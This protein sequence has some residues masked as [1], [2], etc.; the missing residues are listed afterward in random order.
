[1]QKITL[2]QAFAGL[3]L[4]N[5]VTSPEGKILAP[6][7]S[8]LDSAVLRRLELAGIAKIVVQGKPVPDASMGYDAGGRATRL[9]FLFRKYLDD[10]FMLTLKNMLFKHFLLRA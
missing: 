7:D 10:R 5:D 4:A 6:V 3:V 1:M 2:Q 8:T 9:D